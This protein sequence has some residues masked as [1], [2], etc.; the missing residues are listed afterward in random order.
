[1]PYTFLL[2]GKH[3]PKLRRPFLINKF[4]LHYFCPTFVPCV[5]SLNEGGLARADVFNIWS[6]YSNL[7]YKK[8]YGGKFGHRELLPYLCETITENPMDEQTRTTT[9]NRQSKIETLLLNK[10]KSSETFKFDSYYG[11]GEL[12]VKKLRVRSD[13]FGRPCSLELELVYHGTVEKRRWE[14]PQSIGRRRNDEIR[15]TIM[16]RDNHIKTL[17]KVFG[18]NRIEVEKITLK[19][20]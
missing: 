9:K 5:Y 11:N 17:A 14:T 12:I 13:S 3:R 20:K 1:V 19:K 7:P 6:V 10:L 16:W 2:G 4:F 18:I 15:N 8:I